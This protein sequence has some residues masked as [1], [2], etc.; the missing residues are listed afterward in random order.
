MPIE[1]IARL[2]AH[3]AASD[4]SLDLERF[5][6]VTLKRVRPVLSFKI[7][8]NMPICFV[9][10]FLGICGPNAVYTPW[11]GQGA[12]AIA[13][14]NP[15]DPPRRRALRTRGWLR[16]EK[17]RHHDGQ[18]SAIRGLRLLD[19]STARGRSPG[20]GLPSLCSKTRRGRPSG[21]PASTLGYVRVPSARWQAGRLSEAMTQ[22]F[23]SAQITQRPRMIAAGDG[24]VPMSHAEEDA[25]RQSGIEPSMILHPKAHLG[26]TFAAA[27]AIQVGLAAALA[28]QTRCPAVLASCAGFGTELGCFV[29]EAI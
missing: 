1:E 23:S 8:A 5:G 22:M 6:R 3:A 14:G 25:M 29:L 11:E 26:N 18:P 13:A 27:A 9:S 21:R 12:Q 20:R 24:D 17:P 15:C 10:I 16:R 7:L 4:G 2:V 19:A 28:S